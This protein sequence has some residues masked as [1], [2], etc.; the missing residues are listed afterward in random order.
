MESSCRAVHQEI[1]QRFGS[2][3]VTHLHG[4][5][6]ERV[7]RDGRFQPQNI[8]GISTRENG[9]DSPLV[10]WKEYPCKA[11]VPQIAELFLH[12]QREMKPSVPAVEGYRATL[13][14]VISLAGTDLAANKGISRIFSSF[15][16]TCPPRE[17]KH[18]NG[19]CLW[20]SETLLIHR[21]SH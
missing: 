3:Q 13:N 11:I 12:L 5:L 17:G 10:S 15:E 18:Q 2:H 1:S 4:W 14:Y 6:F 16:K 20:F 8:H 19:T 21:K 7:C 9:L